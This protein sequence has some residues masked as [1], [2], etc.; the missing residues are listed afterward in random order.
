MLLL[1]VVPPAVA[2]NVAKPPTPPARTLFSQSSGEL[3]TLGLK[4]ITVDRLSCALGARVPTSLG[5]FVVGDPVAITCKS[6]VL[7]TIRYAPL[8]PS[9]SVPS[10]VTFTTT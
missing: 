8:P 6:G 3:K 10:G 1:V 9:K 2:R 7:S 5:R 4:R